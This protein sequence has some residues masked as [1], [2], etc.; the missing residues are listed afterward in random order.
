M[1]FNHINLIVSDP[2]T[3]ASFYA[4]LLSGSVTRE[5]LGE[6]LHVRNDDAADF[7]FQK[8]EPRI[9]KGSHH[10][11]LAEDVASIDQLLARL[12]RDQVRVTDDCNEEGFRSI[13]F[14]DPDG[15]EIE[16]YWER[17]WP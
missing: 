14:L 4:K 7:A 9:A 12:V 2:E 1:K 6:S 10:G 8:G 11:F 15:Y 16:V 17:N 3:S 13:K 5:W